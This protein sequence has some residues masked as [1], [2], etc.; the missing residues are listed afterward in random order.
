MHILS[1]SEPGAKYLS[2]YDCISQRQLK[3]LQSYLTV[4]Q[5]IMK[6]LEEQMDIQWSYY[7]D[8]VRRNSKCQMRIPCLDG[9]YQQMTKLKNLI[10][11]QQ[12]KLHYIKNIMKQKDLG[13]ARTGSDCRKESTQLIKSDA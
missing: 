11:Q 12:T 1:F 8:L 13:R 9:I 4:N 6:R 7:Q 3:S 10:T 5:S 2:L